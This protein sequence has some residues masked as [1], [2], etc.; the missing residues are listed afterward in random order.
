VKPDYST[1]IRPCWSTEPGRRADM[2]ALFGG[3]PVHL[4][5]V[6]SF[7]TSQ[8]HICSSK[9]TL[10]ENKMNFKICEI[11]KVIIFKNKPRDILQVFFLSSTFSSN[12]P[13]NIFKVFS[14]K[15]DFMFR[16]QLYES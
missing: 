5:A 10:K 16:R 2:E 7:T 11:P 3:R 14:N 8:T 1:L 13:M 4:A 15:F 9:E 12:A 6:R